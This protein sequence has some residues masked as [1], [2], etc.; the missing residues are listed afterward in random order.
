V[1]GV[2]S[3]LTEDSKVAKQ[4]PEKN[5]N[6]DAGAAAAAGEFPCAVTGDNASQ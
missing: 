6:Y 1:V 2:Q 5:E 4:P 3:I